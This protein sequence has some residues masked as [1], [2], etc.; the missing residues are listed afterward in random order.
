MERLDA[1]YMVKDSRSRV[2]VD[3]IL[4][5]ESDHPEVAYLRTCR[6]YALELEQGFGFEQYFVDRATF[7]ATETMRLEGGM[8]KLAARW[9]CKVEDDAAAGCRGPTG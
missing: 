6:T 2:V 5:Q 8:W 7:H 3:D 4:M 1:D 9:D